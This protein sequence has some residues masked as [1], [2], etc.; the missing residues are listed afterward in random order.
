MNQSGAARTLV[1]GSLLLVLAGAGC[2]SGEVPHGPPVLLKMYWQVNGGNSKACATINHDASTDGGDAGSTASNQCLVWSNDSADPDVKLVVPPAPYQFNL[3]FDRVIDGTRVED[4]VTDAGISQQVNKMFCTVDGSAASGQACTNP[5]PV[6]VTFPGLDLATFS[7]DVWY[8]SVPLPIAPTASSYV[9][10]RERPSYPSDTDV[11]IVLDK[12][13]LIGK[14]GD[15]MSGPTEIKVRTAPFSLSVDLPQPPAGQTDSHPPT[16][17]WVP[18]QFSNVL[19]R[20]ADLLSA[21][22]APHVH[23][24]QNGRTLAAGEFLLE[25]DPVDATLVFIRPVNVVR[26]APGADGGVV[27]NPIWD[28]GARIDVTVDGDLTDVYGAKLGAAVSASF[29]ACESEGA[30]DAGLCAPA[31]GGGSVTTPDAGTTSDAAVADDGG[32]AAADVPAGNDDAGDA[33]AATD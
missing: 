25:P 33:A 6:S 1:A 13:R 29:V 31:M 23:V 26:A 27:S 18:L 24:Q 17:F 8:N 16:S 14:Y 9:Y 20:S 12:T 21:A 22:L 10:G 28:S 30:P 11:T 2:G 32:D 15:Q 3:V 5:A 19:V 4:T 7:L